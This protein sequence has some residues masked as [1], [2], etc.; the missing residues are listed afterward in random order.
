M[1]TRI[2]GTGSYVPEKIVT[3]EDLSKIV[4][5]SDEWIR[6]RTGIESRRIAEGM[7]TSQ[8]AVMAALRA[9]LRV[10]G[11]LRRIWILSSLPLPRRIS[12]FPAG[13]VRCRQP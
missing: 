2:I 10:P 11:L 6:T 12:A 3:N 1:T 4:D 8:V 9:L 5:T 7:G 13:P